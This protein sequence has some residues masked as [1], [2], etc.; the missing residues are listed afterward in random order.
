MKISFVLAATFHT[1]E[2]LPSVAQEWELLYQEDFTNGL[3][4]SVNDAQWVLE[5][6]SNPFDTIMDDNGMYVEELCVEK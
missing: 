4:S 1:F 2:V 5:D 6:Y 3:P